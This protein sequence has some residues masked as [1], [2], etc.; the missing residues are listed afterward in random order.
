MANP[1]SDAAAR[2]IV[3]MLGAFMIGLLVLSA[4]RCNQPAPP[5]ASPTPGAVVPVATVSTTPTALVASTATEPV[6]GPPAPS[7]SPQPASTPHIGAYG[8]GGC[9]AQP[10][11]CNAM[12]RERR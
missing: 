9:L 11:H 5:V 4:V 10:E 6:Q 12:E 3:I 8:S 2:G 1:S 7:T